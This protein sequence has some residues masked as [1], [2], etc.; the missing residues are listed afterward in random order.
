ML[1]VFGEHRLGVATIAALLVLSA[2]LLVGYG[3]RATLAAYPLLRLALF[4]I[5]TFRAAVS[6]SFFTRIGIG[7]VPFLFPLLYQVGLGYT[8][9]SRAC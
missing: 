5:R 6:G 7:G 4:K 9:S 8:P 2:L 1:E 3:L